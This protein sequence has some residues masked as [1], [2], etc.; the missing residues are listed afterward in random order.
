MPPSPYVA[1]A[2]SVLQTQLPDC[3]QPRPA[4]L[5]Y[6]AGNTVS[7]YP[8]AQSKM[9]VTYLIAA[10]VVAKAHL[11]TVASFSTP[12]SQCHHCQRRIATPSL[13]ASSSDEES[14]DEITSTYSDAS[15]LDSRRQVLA[16][17]VG[18]VLTATTAAA[19]TTASTVQP[20][21]AAVGS[22]YEFADT[23]AILQ[24]ITVNVA[25][26]S[27]EDAMIAFLENSFDFKVLRKSQLG[28]VTSTWLGFGPE[29]TSVPEGFVPGVSSF[30]EYG[31]HAAI[32]VRYD[33]K[34]T[35]VLYRKG[36]DAP[37]DNIAYLQVGVPT[38]RISQMVKFDGN[39]LDAYGFVNVV[40]PCGLPMRGI[41]GIWP[42]PIMFVAI[43]T[44]DIAQSKAF[45]QQLGFV[46]QEYPYARPNK[47]AGQFEPAQPAK[48][49][50]LAPSPNS[51]GVL[52][53]PTK[54]KKAKITPN[55][56]L[57]SL[58]VVYTPSEGTSEE[59]ANND[60]QL[61][62][63]QSSVPVS[64]VS[65]AKFDKELAKTKFVPPTPQ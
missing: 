25:D 38:Y 13:F 36:G 42:D 52:L 35:D 9:R 3:Y 44:P 27:Q 17:A 58:N 19:A 41:V 37:G 57:R 31:G 34:S 51:M 55:P 7:T 16:K 8:H 1:S 11:P 50:Y 2:A 30:A 12:L 40:S 33:A 64:F 20:A 24:G 28:S 21:N 54:S 43:N 45:Y 62:D 47:G 14:V 59:Q 46:E 5:L 6:N 22:L 18:A 65:S 15:S 48:S 61:E 56:V 49:V 26:K 32:C 60:L 53:L 63:P 39:V 29:Q 10:A 23:N 4:H